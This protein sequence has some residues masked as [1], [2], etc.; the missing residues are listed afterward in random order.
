MSA[1]C[2]DKPAGIALLLLRSA[3]SFET[4]TSTFS[5]RTVR[6][7][8]GRYASVLMLA[9]C[10]VAPSNLGGG[11]RKI[12]SVFHTDADGALEDL[13]GYQLDRL[14]QELRN[15]E[16]LLID[17]ISPDGVAQ[18]ES[19]NRRLQHVARVLHRE[20]FGTESPDDMGLFGGI[21]VVLMCD[22]VQLQPIL[23]SSF[24]AG[25]AIV[26]RPS[27][28]LHARSKMRRCEQT[29]HDVVARRCRHSWRL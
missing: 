3:G 12:D 7:L 8:F 15:V 27:S 11:F 23:A 5:T 26:E 28:G 18:L 29:I 10:G 9:F 6:W 1:Y 25:T 21:V 2:F 24:L 4:H 22:C 19:M 17:E 14:V 13:S 20:Q 16:L